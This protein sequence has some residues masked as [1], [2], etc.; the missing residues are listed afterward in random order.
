[1]RMY[2]LL[3]NRLF[4][5]AVKVNGPSSGPQHTATATLSA[6]A[7][8]NIVNATLMSE[9][10][11]GRVFFASVSKTSVVLLCV[12]SIAFHYFVVAHPRGPNETDQVG[13]RPVSAAPS[14]MVWCYILGSLGLLFIL[15]P[16]RFRP[17]VP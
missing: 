4:D 16:M 14:W 7:V 1:M 3:Y 9:L 6:L 2:R 8:V 15:A 17:P 5:W 11:V 13:S 12:V 10:A